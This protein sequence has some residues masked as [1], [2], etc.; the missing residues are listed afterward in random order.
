MTSVV[1]WSIV[2]G[3]TAA[4]VVVTMVGGRI[5]VLLEVALGAVVEVEVEVDVD[6]VAAPRSPTE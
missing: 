3:T 5:V 4:T 6:V 1:V 2:D